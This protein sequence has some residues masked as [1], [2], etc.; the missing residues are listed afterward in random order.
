MGSHGP[1]SQKGMRSMDT[2]RSDRPDDQPAQGSGERLAVIRRVWAFSRERLATAAQLSVAAIEELERGAREPTDTELD[3]L[4]QA[5]AVPVTALAPDALVAIDTTTL[6][7][8]VVRSVGGTTSTNSHPRVGP[9]GVA[10]RPAERLRAAL[11]RLVA[12][13]GASRPRLAPDPCGDADT[14]GARA[15][16]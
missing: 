15:Q 4:A 3:R 7:I 14:A 11:R 10:G 13:C 9:L 6:D 5:L 2:P 1:E 8:M 16:A 12:P